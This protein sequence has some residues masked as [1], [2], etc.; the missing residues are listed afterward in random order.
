MAIFSGMDL[1]EWRNSQGVSAEELGLR[2]GYDASTV[3]RIEKGMQVPDS[4]M[5]MR[6]C[7]AMGDRSRYD[8]WMRTAW[9]DSYG[10]MVPE[11][12]YYSLEGTILTLYTQLKDVREL[13]RATMEDGADGKIDSFMLREK[14]LK[15]LTELISAAQG[16][17]TL[18]EKEG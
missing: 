13:R 12:T 18:L 4:N 5:M 2:I 10:R 8:T 11:P 16:A 15:E 1:R 6:I 17:K 14:L 3:Y 7:D 9:P